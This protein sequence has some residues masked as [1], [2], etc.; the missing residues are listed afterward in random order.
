MRPSSARG[1]DDGTTKDFAALATKE[2]GF[3]SLVVAN[4][5]VVV[6]KVVLLSSFQI[7]LSESLRRPRLISLV[8]TPFAEQSF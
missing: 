5:V 6:S 2:N 8:Q 7:I 4:I 1:D 3:S